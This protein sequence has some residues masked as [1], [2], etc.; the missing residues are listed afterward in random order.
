MRGCAPHFI[1]LYAGVDLPTGG[2]EEEGLERPYH[3]R[4]PMPRV[5]FS[6]SSVTTSPSLL[7]DESLLCFHRPNH[8]TKPHGRSRG[9]LLGVNLDIFDI[10]SIADG[11]FFYKVSPAYQD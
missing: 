2:V 7:Y 5:A 6:L 8:G 10:G 3:G 9:I 4:V 1:W 11:V